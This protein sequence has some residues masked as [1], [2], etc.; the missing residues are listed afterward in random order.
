MVLR[1]FENFSVTSIRIID[2]IRSTKADPK[3]TAGNS[4]KKTESRINA[5]YRAL[6]LPTIAIADEN[7]GGNI[8]DPLNHGNLHIRESNEQTEGILGKLTR[9]EADFDM[10]IDEEEVK[11][12][13]DNN[14]SNILGSIDETDAKRTRG[15]LFPMFANG[16]I[17]IFPQSNRV[18]GAFFAKDQV[19][20]EV[21]YRRPLIELIVLLRLKEIGAQNTITQNV[22]NKN[23][24]G[25]GQ[26]VINFFA[27]TKFNF[28]LVTL[29][30][31]SEL[32]KSIFE[33]DE[34]IKKT[35]EKTN[36]LRINSKI[37]F[38][39]KSPYVAEAQPIVKES[40]ETG[41]LEAL[42]KEQLEAANVNNAL[43]S[44]IE[45][46]D[47]ITDGGD[48]TKNM[49]NALLATL[50]LSLV[51]SDADNIGEQ[52]KELKIEETKTIRELKAS[53]RSMDLLIGTF[54]GISGVDILI[55]IAALFTMD[56]ASLLGLFD[57]ASIE[58]LKLL[59]DGINITR[60]SDLFASVTNLENRVSELFK[61]VQSEVKNKKIRS[62][63]DEN[64]AGG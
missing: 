13:L 1:N 2:E 37:I 9:R 3:N 30:L 4:T 26:E 15:V 16:K 50:V 38:T 53:Q 11:Q 20:D 31:I 14:K 21:L 5:F 57:D 45:Y 52:T 27:P 22:V 18:A 23:F 7:T 59:K 34:F 41:E 6:G 44:L 51:T 49:K 42:K 58:R 36:K 63:R 47:T 48:I 10:P 54:S 64:N 40:E 62:R 39:D 29:E 43:L 28:N 55:V 19:I 25:L 61:Q 35:R 17:G 8:F 46:D 56:E 24:E 60:N 32:I 33:I 12:F